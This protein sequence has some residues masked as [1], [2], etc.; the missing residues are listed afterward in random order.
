MPSKPV[1]DLDQLLA[2]INGENPT[3]EE[4]SI[5]D[6]DS[7]FLRIK[8]MWDEARKLVK[9][10]MDCERSGGIDSQGQPWR[11]IPTPAWDRVI[12]DATEIL[13]S[14]SKDFR[15]A[16]WLTEAL[17]RKD[18]AAGLRDGLKLCL[19]FCEQYWEQI[20]PAANE[21]DGHSVTV[22][23]FSGLVSDATFPAIQDILIVRGQKEGEREVR[24]YSARDY[25]RAK[26]LESN[27]NPEERAHLIEQGHVEF[28]EIQAVASVTDP[29]FF[30]TGIDDLTECIDL[31]K[32]LGEFLRQN[33]KDDQYDEPTY[34]G[35]TPFREQL[36]AVR[37]L[38]MEFRGEDVAEDESDSGG[39][40]GSGGTGGPREGGMT[41]ETAFQAVERIAQFFEKTEPHTPVHFALRQAIRWGRMS[42]P[43]LLGELIE[44]H[45]S[46]EQLRKVVGLPPRREIDQA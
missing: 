33:C 21:E 18:F 3:G 46:M 6:A 36:E 25:V 15:I 8:D 7:P 2:P 38:L 44:D 19:G 13:A 5:A 17:L 28:K 14:K 16:A 22:G 9:E 10:K 30:T 27:T 23:P 12:D 20:R 1:L 40:G 42:L 39:E 26:E 37:K 34:P 45:G 11:T 35:I 29:E 41:R 31:I 24:K 32:K 4:L 43:E